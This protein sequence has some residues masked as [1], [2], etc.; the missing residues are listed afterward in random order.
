MS[1]DVEELASIAG[2]KHIGKVEANKDSGRRV[3][4]YIFIVSGDVSLCGGCAGIYNEFHAVS[5][6]NSILIWVEI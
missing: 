4:F 3:G 1:Y 5:C 6:S 2:V